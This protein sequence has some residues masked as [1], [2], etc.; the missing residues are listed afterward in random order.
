MGRRK[1]Y[2]IWQLFMLTWL[3]TVGSLLGLG[4]H[5]E[6]V[7]KRSGLVAVGLLTLIGFKFSVA[8]QLPR[9]SYHT[10]ADTYLQA[11]VVLLCAIACWMIF[12]YY[13]DWEFVS[14]SLFL[15]G[16]FGSTAH[17]VCVL[18]K[19]RQPWEDVLAEC[20]YLTDNYRDPAIGKSR[21]VSS[22][23]SVN[24]LFSEAIGHST[25]SCQSSQSSRTVYS[26]D[27]ARRSSF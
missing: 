24:S 4:M 25:A 12:Q 14:W 21:K 9:V 17:F 8:E 18:R 27:F 22:R 2:Y 5:G 15:L 11:Q 20:G 3:I 23:V 26:D 1:R 16:V 10:Y 13:F 7:G 6:Y 19:K